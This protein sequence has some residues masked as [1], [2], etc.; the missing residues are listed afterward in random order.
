[1]ID[2]DQLRQVIRDSLEPLD[3]WSPEAAEL[4][5]GTAA[6][7]SRLGTYVTQLGG[8]PA[9][10]IFQM[11]PETYHDIWD[12]YLKYNIVLRSR[13]REWV[14]RTPADLTYDMRQSCIMARLHYRRVPEALPA[15]DDLDGQARYWKRYYNTTLGRGTTCEYKRSYKELVA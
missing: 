13:V 12:N 1:M 11:E 3:L 15:V 4:L 2:K 6:Q 10:G 8:G 14:T 7:E 9:L 5:M